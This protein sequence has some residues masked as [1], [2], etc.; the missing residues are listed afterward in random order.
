LPRRRRIKRRLT[1]M[2][3][4][5]DTPKAPKDVLENLLDSNIDGE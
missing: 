2:M 5:P 4:Y 1:M 3:I